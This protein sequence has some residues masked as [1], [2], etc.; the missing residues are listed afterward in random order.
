MSVN[1]DYV[2]A[3][4]TG[5]DRGAL[6]DQLLQRAE[7]KYGEPEVILPDV[8]APDVVTFVN[9]LLTFDPRIPGLVPFLLFPKQEEF[10]LWLQQREF[11][12]EN[13][14][15]EKSRDA[16]VSYLC[17]AYALWT[18]LFRANTAVGFGSRK[19][20][21]VDT[22]GAPDSL[23]EK[24]RILLRSVKSD[25]LPIGFDFKR[26]S[27][28]CRLINPANG[29]VIIGEGG[30]DIGR[31][32]RN[33]LYFVDEAAF[34]EHPDLIERSLSA[35]TNVRIDVSTPN[36]IGNPF[37]K[38]RTSGIVSV[39]TFHWKDD[40]RKNQE[41]AAK[42]K[43]EC[44]PITW[45]QEYE[46][47]YS[48]SVEGICIPGIWVRASVGLELPANGVHEAGLDVADEGRN[49]N[50]FI[51]RVG[52][53]IKD[54]V[55]WSQM[56]TTQT[57]WKAA[58]QCRRFGVETLH[59]DCIGVG[60]GVKGTY[61]SAEKPLGF[62]TNPIQSGLPAGDDK[63][64]D[65]KRSKERFLNIR[66]ELWWKLRCRFEKT[67]EYVT[68]KT[69]HPAEEMISLPDVPEL[70][71]QLSMPLYFFTD[72][73]KMKIESKVDMK[74]RGIESPDYADALVYAFYPGKRI[75]RFA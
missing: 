30:D 23:F 47:D 8:M 61:N 55:S 7:Y 13:G 27:S 57:A 45:A 68:L 33:T 39:F 32:G 53:V 26:H 21:L 4:S 19:L 15:V 5:F 22:L 75:G 65:G 24:I 58:E 43:A 2:P 10:L 34:L 56:N 62:K 63:W 40:D 36:G 73:G 60:A 1:L 46:I 72:T 3:F 25:W 17:C 70:I 48:A 52:P 20:T 38:K 51:H 64:P 35:N 49:K 28:T 67:F 41:W 14:L 16:G 74:K 18:W 44:D 37:H 50:V 69:E 31:G 71:S 42:K 29:S 59:Y 12:Q 6:F 54:V 11:H 9:S 66:A